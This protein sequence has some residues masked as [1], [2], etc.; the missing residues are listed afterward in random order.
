MRLNSADAENLRSSTILIWDECTMA[1]SI[2]L[3]VV[4]KLLK[5]IMDN[6]KPFGGKVLLL[7]GD[8][9][10]TLPVVP[11]GDRTKIVE[12]CIKYNKLWQKF[13]ILNLTNNI[14]SV[15]TEFSNWLIQVGNGDTPHIDGLPED[16]I[17][18][19]SKIIC[20]GNIVKE[21]FGERIPVADVSKITKKCIL[22][23]KNSDV[24]SINEEVLN[25]LEGDTVTFLSSNSIDDSTEEDLQN[26]PVEFLNELTP[27]GM[28]R[29][30]LNLKKGA[31]IMLL[32]N[33]NTKKGLCNGTRLFVKDLK[34]NLIIAQVIT[35][36]AEG[37]MVFIPRIDLAPSF[38]T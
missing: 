28:P 6:H 7:G 33:I 29:H 21:L 8:F 30:K 25:I 22:C 37:D 9:R 35:G 1:P 18:I 2:A 26:Y 20:T 12:A 16:I 17:E 4:D 11:H 3:T 15:D 34:K 5:E 23:P 31:I 32:R 14:R 27:T 38:I 13:R 24:D 36:S 10:Q 19:P